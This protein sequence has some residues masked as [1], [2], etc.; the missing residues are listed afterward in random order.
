MRARPFA[1]VFPL[2]L[3][4]LA[5]SGC[6]DGDSLGPATGDAGSAGP[7]DAGATSNPFEGGGV[8][9]GV[10]CTPNGPETRVVVTAEPASCEEHARLLAGEQQND[11]AVILAPQVAGPTQFD[12][13]AEICLSGDCSSRSAQVEIDA[14]G[15]QGAIGRWTIPLDDE[16]A[17][18]A[19][20]APFCEYDAF[21]PGD[22][23]TLVP[24]LAVSQV[25]IYQGPKIVLAG[26]G[27]EDVRSVPVVEGREAWLR[28]FVTPQPGFTQQDVIGELTWNPGDG[29]E[30]VIFEDR[31]DIF[32]DSVESVRATTLNFT[33]PGEL[34][35]ASA[36]WSV[37]LRSA[38]ACGGLA[39]DT[40]GALEPGEGLADLAPEP[41]GDLDVVLVPFRYDADGSGRLPDLSETQLE[42]YRK[43]FLG[44]YP[45][46]SV[47]LSVRAAL[48][49]R[50]PIQPGGEGWSEA[51]SGLLATRAQDAPRDN[52]FYYGVFSP[53]TSLGRFCRRGCVLGLGV[54]PG[55]AQV[56][57]RGAI[58]LGFGGETTANTAAHEIG[59]A[60][61]RPHAPCG[62]GDS[63][64]EWPRDLAYREADIG[65]WSY[66]ITDGSLKSPSGFKDIMSYCEPE[67]ISD[68]NYRKLYERL[69]FVNASARSIRGFVSTP[70]RF[71]SLTED[72]GAS[73]G[74]TVTMDA[75][76]VGSEVPVLYLDGFGQ[77]LAEDWA[78][79]TPLD[80]L[81]GEI[82]TLPEGPSG[83]V[84]VQIGERAPI[85]Y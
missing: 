63:D 52:T 26:A 10:I 84:A 9:I 66:D 56:S 51:L 25:A 19:L 22:D 55:P 71:L 67:W 41:V 32:Q 61:G 81:N 58:G 37:A 31:K 15:P 29:R 83:T 46:R 80:H 11:Q 35:T 18:G 73:W 77:P 5:G 14:F 3:G 45:T 48:P 74:S 33:V 27:L 64:P 4:G 59:H 24:N 28:A 76:P 20:D 85:L 23:P 49:W 50:L 38:A 42:R 2:I 1:Y 16:L 39:G 62:V 17:T 82:L 57:R 70:Y 21:L 13:D 36:Q 72:Y 68:F 79:S 60:H 54:L 43:K 75:P 78:V 12:A 44:M 65:V 30:A 8:T 34:V 40:T 53:S 69:S 47:N 6:D 7:A